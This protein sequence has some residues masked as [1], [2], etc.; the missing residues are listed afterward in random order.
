MGIQ[1]LLP[2]VQ[3][4]TRSIHV[5]EFTGC[6]VAIDSHCWLHRAAYA[7]SEKLAKGEVT[8]S[9]VS[10]CMRFIHMLKGHSITPIMVFDGNALP[11]KKGVHDSRQQKK[12]A[13]RLQGEK[14]E[15]EGNFKEARNCYNQ[16]LDV[17]AVMVAD[18]IAALKEA[19]VDY[20]VA[21]FEA[22]AQLAY[23]VNQGIAHIVVTE[24]SDL[25]PFGC[26]RILFK[27]EIS[28]NGT[29][30]E[31]CHL[32]KCLS[33]RAELLFSPTRRSDEMMFT[34]FRY[35]CIMSGCDYHPGGLP[36]VGL[37]KA[38]KAMIG[39]SN[40]LSIEKMLV[41]LP[42][43]LQNMQLSITNDYKEKFIRANETFLHQIVF[44]PRERKLVPVTPLPVGLD[45]AKLTHAGHG[46]L[47]DWDALHMAMGEVQVEYRNSQGDSDSQFSVD[48]VRSPIASPVS[49]STAPETPRKGG[50]WCSTYRMP[51]P[52]KSPPRIPLV[53][54]RTTAGEIVV[55]DVLTKTTATALVAPSSSTQPATPPAANKA[56][57]RPTGALTDMANSPSPL[58]SR[59]K[60]KLFDADCNDDDPA[61]EIPRPKTPQRKK[62]PLFIA[63]QSSFS[64]PAPARRVERGRGLP[65]PPTRSAVSAKKELETMSIELKSSYFSSD[66]TPP[67]VSETGERSPQTIVSPSPAGTS[68]TASPDDSG[69]NDDVTISRTTPRQ[70]H[71]L[72][73]RPPSRPETAPSASVNFSFASFSY[74]QRSN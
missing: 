47:S 6:T 27:L 61:D 9:Y 42:Q 35:A 28:G 43:Y 65:L 11:S 45:P 48:S 38:T 70:R 2:F 67:S 66:M 62:C 49:R 46:I 58:G 54:R 29:L 16:S 25:I 40:L 26:N 31:R 56:L 8:T 44:D 5:S 23:L 20:I 18:V 53:R 74:K 22:D 37:L 14:F 1:G 63:R 41:R 73:V 51:S 68:D 15:T 69:H 72:T 50:I 52:M 32:Y 39:C 64:A 33:P 30:Y 59:V 19:Q 7:C 12:R 60:R 17:T 10:Y 3:K 55:I 36:G 71:P 24:D 21:P 13:M 34:R 4:A 57:K